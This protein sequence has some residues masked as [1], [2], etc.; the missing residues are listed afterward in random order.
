MSIYISV[1]NA[2]AA[3]CHRKVGRQIMAMVRW[4]A[5]AREH[6]S[7]WV[8]LLVRALHEAKSTGKGPQ[9]CKSGSVEFGVFP[10]SPACSCLRI[11]AE[12]GKRLFWSSLSQLRKSRSIPPLA[13]SSS[14]LSL[15][16]TDATGQRKKRERTPPQFQE[17]SPALSQK[18]RALLPIALDRCPSFPVALRHLRRIFCS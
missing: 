1:W 15:P 5:C 3:W 6:M 14:S 2:H 11:P 7:T 9:G 16:L 8:C 17:A 12:L 10:A 4:A 13:K 18:K